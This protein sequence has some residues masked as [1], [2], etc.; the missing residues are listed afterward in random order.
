[1]S[2]TATHAPVVLEPASQAFVEATAKP[3][4]L[5]QL[6]PSP[7]NRDTPRPGGSCAKPAGH[8]TGGTYG[9]AADSVR[10]RRSRN[11]RY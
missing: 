8:M 10:L 2:V 5:Y 11:K 3:P 1:M 4:F 7:S 9:Y 6:T